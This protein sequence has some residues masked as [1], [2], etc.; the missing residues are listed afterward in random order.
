MIKGGIRVGGG[1]PDGPSTQLPREQQR[2]QGRRRRCGNRT[3]SHAHLFKFCRVLRPQTSVE[4]S[5]VAGLTHTLH[6]FQDASSSA[7]FPP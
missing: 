1:T 6:K 7:F 4:L 2:L 5:M 3:L